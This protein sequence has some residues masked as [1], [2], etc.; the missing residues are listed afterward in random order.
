MTERNY[1]IIGTNEECN[2]LGGVKPKYV[3]NLQS[4]N[5]RKHTEEEV[6]VAQ[7]L[8][9]NASD[10]SSMQTNSPHQADRE[11]LSVE[12][13]ERP[14]STVSTDS[15]QSQRENSIQ[16]IHLSGREVDAAAEAKQENIEES[17]IW[18]HITR[19]EN[20]DLKAKKKL[21]VMQSSIDTDLAHSHGIQSV[22]VQHPT[23]TTAVPSSL[24]EVTS[25]EQELKSA[26]RLQMK[27]VEVGSLPLRVQ[28]FQQSVQQKNPL[29][30]GFFATIKY[31]HIPLRL[32]ESTFIMWKETLHV[33][34]I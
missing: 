32:V 33:R 34:F 7:V 5:D 25:R 2:L 23:V 30:P 22:N 1:K 15:R 14:D 28:N 20:I 26:S 12:R 4:A 9:Q 27:N 10:P 17:M 8:T 24:K 31:C 18:N 19:P 29:R 11:S 6:C 16:D 13:T 3:G 21:E